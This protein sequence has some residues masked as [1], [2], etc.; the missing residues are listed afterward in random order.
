MSAGRAGPRSMWIPNVVAV[1]SGACRG[2]QAS[3]GSEPSC[4]L[5]RA[6]GLLFVVRMGKK[7]TQHFVAERLTRLGHALKLTRGWCARRG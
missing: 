5:L 2:P 4:E 1:S 6:E 7:L 3:R